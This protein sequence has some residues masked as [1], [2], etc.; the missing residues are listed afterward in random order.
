VASALTDIVRGL[1]DRL[2]TPRLDPLAFYDATVAAM[3]DDGTVDIKTDVARFGAGLS[4]VPIRHGLPGVSVR[5]A[6]GARVR[7]GFAGGDVQQPFVALWD[8]GSLEELTVTA[9]T[10][11]LLQSPSVVVAQVEGNAKPVARLGDLVKVTGVSGPPGAPIE[12]V[13]YILDGAQ[14]LSSE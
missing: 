2:V 12:F 7:L 4:R 11:L 1:I 13:G 8:P 5:V 14:K 10:K 3:N 6:R 9:S